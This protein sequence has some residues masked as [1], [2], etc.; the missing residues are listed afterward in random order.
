VSKA[1]AKKSY[2]EEGLE[3]VQQEATT[4]AVSTENTPSDDTFHV[5][6]GVEPVEFFYRTSAPKKPTKSP[7]KILE[8]GQVIEGVY[9]KSFTAGK[10]NN[11]TFLIRLANGNLIGLPSAGSLTKAMNRVA[12]GAKVKITYEGMA[13]IKGGQWAGS[14]AHN[15]SV[16]ASKLKA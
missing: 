6:S 3:E 15:Y 12:E 8:K 11:P 5:V 10:F 13:T 4:I 16:L 9:E 2:A 1:N 7:F 14:D